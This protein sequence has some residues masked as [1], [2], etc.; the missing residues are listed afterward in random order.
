MAHGK[1][2]LKACH[3]EGCSWADLPSLPAVKL[4]LTASGLG[5][6][7]PN[8]LKPSLNMTTSNFTKAYHWDLARQIERPDFLLKWIPRYADWGYDQVYLYLE[9]A[10]DSPSVP[11][12][13]LSLIHI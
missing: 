6:Q 5:A 9:D 1:I 2:S 3:D 13:G 11:G 8:F 7:S 4:I 10:F 12:I